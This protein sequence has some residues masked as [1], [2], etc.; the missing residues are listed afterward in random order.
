MAL[1]R[2]RVLALVTVATLAAPVRADD[3]ADALRRENQALRARVAALEAEVAELR[4]LAGVAV[5]PGRE[6]DSAAR[7]A[8]A[9]DERRGTTS[10]TGR[11][12]R[13]EVLHGVRG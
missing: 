8:T 12:S 3:V 7:V 1:V 4:V 9:F 13:L 10:V 5:A 11:A 6:A 2:R